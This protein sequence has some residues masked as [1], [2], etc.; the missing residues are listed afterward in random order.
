[1]K[2]MIFK[3]AIKIVLLMLS[4]ISLGQTIKTKKTDALPKSSPILMTKREVINFCGCIGTKLPSKDP[5][6]FYEYDYQKLMYQSA[7]IDLEEITEEEINEKLREWW[8]LNKRILLCDSLQ[9]PQ[10]NGSVLKYASTSNT[11]TFIDEAITAGFDLNMVD[12]SDNR[13]LL[14]YVKDELKKR[15][16]TVLEN[17]LLMTYNKLRKAGAKYRSEL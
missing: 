17:E 4:I 5:G 13:T 15:K 12:K 14:D 8:E 3:G 11:W 1:M 16:G 7:G 10:P 6:G 9:F 2:T